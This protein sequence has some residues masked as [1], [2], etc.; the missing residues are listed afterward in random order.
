MDRFKLKLDIYRDYDLKEAVTRMGPEREALSPQID[1]DEL[2]EEE[3]PL[4]AWVE[5]RQERDV[6][7]FDPRD[8]SWAEGELDG[9]EARDP[10]LRVV[11]VVLLVLV[12]VLVV[13]VV[14][15]L[16]VLVVLVVVVLVLVLVLVLLPLG[17]QE[18]A[19]E[20]QDI[21]GPQV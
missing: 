5:T 1:V 21:L 2:F 20:M 4:N 17:P 18:L 7:E 16:V 14:L 19:K 13:L 11:V 12:V 8:C 10:E 15:M 3:H 6:L 9:V